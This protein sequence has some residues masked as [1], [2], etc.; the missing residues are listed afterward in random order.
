[1]EFRGIPTQIPGIHNI[2]PRGLILILV[3]TIKEFTRNNGEFL[4]LGTVNAF[5]FVYHII[6]R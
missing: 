3:L 2:I 6:R 4:R 1:M 5:K